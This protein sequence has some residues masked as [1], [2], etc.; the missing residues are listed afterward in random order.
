MKF[1]IKNLLC[2]DLEKRTEKDLRT[3]PIE[4]SREIIIFG[5]PLN[6]SMAKFKENI[7]VWDLK[8]T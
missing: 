5:T 8:V 1:T 7:T 4:K 3:H 2:L 6:K